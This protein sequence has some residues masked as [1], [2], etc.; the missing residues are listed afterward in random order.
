M[1]KEKIK[2]IIIGLLI[3]VIVSG[4]VV[5]AKNG[6]QW[7]EAIYSDIK[8]SINGREITP[9]D[10]NGN[11]VEPFTIN[12]TTYLPVRA[13]SSALDK[14]VE[15]ND[16]TKTV[17]ISD[18]SEVIADFNWYE[19]NK[20]YDPYVDLVD[21][22]IQTNVVFQ[23]NGVVKNFK[24]IELEVV[25][26]TIYPYTYELVKVRYEKE[27]LGGRTKD[28]YLDDYLIAAVKMPTGYFSHYG[29]TYT[30]D[31]GE[32]K[33]FGLTDVGTYREGGLYRLGLE[34]IKLVDLKK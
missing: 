15:W 32:T 9:K 7:I 23:A 24:I 4:S 14:K 12:G 29:M 11:E 20:N 8:I 27:Q 18:A 1:T 17:E 3:G 6:S 5:F 16:D 2:G 25:D 31:N 22:D 28:G 30:N 21:D 19:I 33:V 26:T 10:V 34:E 13:I